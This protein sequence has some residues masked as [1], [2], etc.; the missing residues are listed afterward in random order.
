[1]RDVGGATSRYFFA[2]CG[3]LRHQDFTCLVWDSGKPSSFATVTGGGGA[4]P[5]YM[6]FDHWGY[7]ARDDALK[8]SISMVECNPPT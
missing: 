6:T 3:L 1:M 4:D 7:M 2:G 8:L 5:N